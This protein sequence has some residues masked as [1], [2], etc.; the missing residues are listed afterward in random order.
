MKK[1]VFQYGLLSGD[2]SYTENT[3]QLAIL[4]EA[5]GRNLTAYWQWA[6]LVAPNGP[7]SIEFISVPFSYKKINLLIFTAIALI[8]T[9]FFDKTDIRSV[10]RMFLH[11]IS[12]PEH[13]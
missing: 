8:L 13:V 10:F 4:H 2:L 6:P 9:L 3:S 1:I 7:M 5:V 11:V 12:F